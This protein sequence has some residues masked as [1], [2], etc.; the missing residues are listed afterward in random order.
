MPLIGS[1][2]SGK[3]W[4]LETYTICFPYGK[5]TQQWKKHVK[6]YS[7][8]VVSWCIQFMWNRWIVGFL[9]VLM[10]CQ[11]RRKRPPSSNKDGRKEPGVAGV[12]WETTQSVATG[13]T[14]AVVPSREPAAS[15]RQERLSLTSWA[16]N[17]FAG[18][19]SELWQQDFLSQETWKSNGQILQARFR[20]RWDAWM[21]QRPMTFKQDVRFNML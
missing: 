14:E 6:N 10:D 9:Q 16:V 8:F 20:M 1:I 5:L 13:V 7:P 17:G 4:D 15:R 3:T 2:P 18:A 21:R 11:V 12:G 19:I